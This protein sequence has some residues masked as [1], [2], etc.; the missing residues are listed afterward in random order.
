MIG[1]PKSGFIDCSKQSNRFSALNMIFKKRHNHIRKISAILLNFSLNLIFF[2]SSI[3]GKW[4]VFNLSSARCKSVAE[5]I[6]LSFA[7]INHISMTNEEK[8]GNGSKLSPT[9]SRSSGSS[10]STLTDGRH[11]RTSTTSNQATGRTKMR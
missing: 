5:I 8:T 3:S 9:G 4:H 11:S 2:L 10:E 6:N 1:K 7:E